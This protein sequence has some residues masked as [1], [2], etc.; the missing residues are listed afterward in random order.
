MR[1]TRPFRG[2]S[3]SAAGT[4]LALSVMYAGT[5]YGWYFYLTWLP[6]YLLRAR[7]F[8]L[9]QAGTL[10]ALPLLSIAAGVFFGGW[11]CD[12]LPK[13]FGPRTSRRIQGMVGLPLAALAI[14]SA[15]LTESP[16][17]SACLLSAAAG[18]AAL[19]VAPAWA[20]CLEIGGAHAGVVTGAM[21]TFGNLGGALSPVV[22]GLC[23]KSFTSFDIPLFSVAALYLVAAVA[24][25]AVDPETPLFPTRAPGSP[26]LPGGVLAG[27]S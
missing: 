21:N 14:V 6:T 19:G 8:N 18:C 20:V 22:V 5:I 2:A 7:G 27:A 3:S 12:H 23:L 4:L 16:L 17:G 24:W 13:Y 26:S 25:F 10:G 15:T 11:L 1:S 9:K